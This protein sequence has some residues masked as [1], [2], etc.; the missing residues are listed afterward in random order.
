MNPEQQLERF[1]LKWIQTTDFKD[2]VFS[3]GG[4]VRDQ[5]LNKPSK[6]LDIVVNQRNGAKNF[7]HYLHEN[8]MGSTSQPYELGAGYPIWHI[9]FKDNIEYQGEIFEVCGAKMDVADTQKEMFPDNAS[10]QRITGFGT[11]EEDCY[12]RDFSINSLYRN[13]SNGKLCDITGISLYDIENGII[14]CNPKVS[15]DKI[16]NDDPLR[17]L[18]AIVFKTR[19]DWKIHYN[20]WKSIIRNAFRIQIVSKERILV[21]LIKTIKTGKFYQVIELMDESGLLGYI[22][23]EIVVLKTVEQSPRHHAEGIEITCTNFVDKSDVA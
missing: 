1:L 14:R 4:Y 23:P 12:R 9:S 8:F 15:S 17:M 13:L 7:T 2:F 18:R 22:L 5:V 19:F 10:R 11:L 3:V 20:T 21:E 6:D 16:F